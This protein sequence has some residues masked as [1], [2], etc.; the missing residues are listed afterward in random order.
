MDCLVKPYAVRKSRHAHAQL[1]VFTLAPPFPFLLLDLV[2][3]ADRCSISTELDGELLFIYW[4][5]GEH[6]TKHMCVVVE[7]EG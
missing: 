3:K 5:P 2:V 1:Y 6:V 7:G 4:N